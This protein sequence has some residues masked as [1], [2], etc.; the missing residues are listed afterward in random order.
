M[1]SYGY[2]W[3]GDK[4]PKTYNPK[5]EGDETEHFFAIS[6]EDSRDSGI[7]QLGFYDEQDSRYYI[8]EKVDAIKKG[9]YYKA[10]HIRKLIDKKSINESDELDWIKDESPKSVLDKIFSGNNNLFIENDI[11]DDHM[12]EI[13]KIM[14]PYGYEWNGGGIPWKPSPHIRFTAVVTD[15]NKI[16]WY[17]GSKGYEG[18]KEEAMKSPNPYYYTASYI[19][20]LINSYK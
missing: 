16:I 20:G 4:Y 14:E 10:S 6:T 3:H 7:Y 18:D 11:E 5:L 8:E 9:K 19:M 13:Q 15:R 1:N 12:M 2:K 17:Y